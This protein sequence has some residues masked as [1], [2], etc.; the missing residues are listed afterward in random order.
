MIAH[1]MRTPLNALTLSV[2]NAKKAADSESLKATLEIIERNTQALASIVNALLE[3]DAT[4]TGRLTLEECLPSDLVKG[5]VDQIT[6]MMEQKHLRIESGNLISLPPIVA[7]CTRIVRVL[8]NLLSNAIRFSPEGGCIRVDAHPRVNDGYPVLV[9]SV[10][11]DGPGVPPE[12]ID[13]IFLQGVSLSHEGKASTG[14]GLTVCKE[15]VEAHGGRIWVETGHTT[16]A[17]FSFSVPTK[18]LTKAE[19]PSS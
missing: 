1:D 12:T 13:R 14:L 16:G 9:F 2:T 19:H 3:V 5:A 7:D 10:S 15:L 8:A 18:T 4:G 17:T 11:D 6:P